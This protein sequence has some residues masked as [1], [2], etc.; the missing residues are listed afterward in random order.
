MQVN[1]NKS[2]VEGMVQAISA[3]M[4]ADEFIA[5]YGDHDRYELIDGELID[6]EPTGLHEQVAAFIL[7]KINVQIDQSNPSWFTPTRCLI[8]PLGIDIAFRPDVIVLDRTTLASEPLWKKEPIITSGVSV[9][10]VVEVVSSNWQNDYARKV[11]DYAALG[12]PE[13]W[14]CDY[15]GA[16]GK[17]F[18]GDPKQPTFS[19][20]TLNKTAY[21][22]QRF[23]GSEPILSFTFPD[24]VL[25]ADQVFAA[26]R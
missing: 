10:L 16:G 6:M 8:S 21:Q 18:L 20:Y 5:R 12:I 9:R 25:T 11:E 3:R 14:V 24:L 13:Y 7:R 17:L 22:V 4:T 1:Q 23:H 19:V 2:E 15:L 26:G